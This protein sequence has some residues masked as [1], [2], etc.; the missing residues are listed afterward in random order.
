MMPS[1]KE[2]ILLARTTTTQNDKEISSKSADTRAHRTTAQERC[3]AMLDEV[4]ESRRNG[5]Y[6]LRAQH[7]EPDGSNGFFSGFAWKC[8]NCHKF[9]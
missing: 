3:H 9:I 7:S 2:T 6:E 5:T 4:K 8:H 1:H